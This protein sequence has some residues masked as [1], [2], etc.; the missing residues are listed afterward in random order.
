[1]YKN[2]CRACSCLCNH[3]ITKEKYKKK[4]IEGYSTKYI[5][6][7]IYFIVLCGDTTCPEIIRLLFFKTFSP[8]KY[9]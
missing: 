2:E 7:C 3:K 6:M 5:Y 9:N 4:K 8:S 1:M